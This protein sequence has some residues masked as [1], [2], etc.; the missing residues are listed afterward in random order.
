[1][2]A[3]ND[4]LAV[5][6]RGELPTALRAH[7]RRQLPEV[8]VP[9]RF[10]VLDRLPQLPNGKVD[11]ARLVELDTAEPTGDAYV[12]PGTPEEA[13][14]ALIWQDVLGLP[15]VGVRDDF[16][17][18][19]GDSVA[20]TQVVARVRDELGLAVSVR[21]MFDR[22]TVA[23]LVAAGSTRPVAGNARSIP[24]AELAAEAVLPDDV[25]PVGAPPAPPYRR[26]LLTGGTGYTGAFL[27]REVL[28]R[29]D[30]H[31]V[32]LA[33]ARDR[34]H[35]L[36]RV[37][38]TLRTYGLWQ[39]E[40]AGRVSALP[41]ELA[42]PYLGLD[43][44]AYREVAQ[45]CEVILH[46]GATSSYALPYRSL[47]AA[48]VLGTLEVLRLAGRGRV[49]PVHFVSSLAVFPGDRGAH[50]YPEAPLGGAEGVVGGYRQTKWVADRMVT[51]AAAR[52]LPVSVYRP[53][54]ITGAQDTGACAEDTFLNAM[55]KGCVQL[56]AALEFD[57]RLEMTPVDVC[58]AT[59]AHTALVR[60]EHGQIV[61]LPGARSV[62]W[63]ELVELMAE[64][65]Y[66]LRRLPYPQ[67][68]AELA[69]AAEL[70]RFLPLFGP[71]GPSADLG[72]EH[73][74][75]TFETG[76]LRRL[77]AGTDIAYRPVD[78][79]LV[80]TYLDWFARTGFLPALAGERA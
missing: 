54:Q 29:S 74:V 76:T 3:A 49:K 61:H 56:G 9:A 20:A 60:G 80:G 69:A 67:W 8:M 44:A 45:S 51:A 79:G 55:I 34:A 68:Y 39:P 78:A 73:A 66:G 77:L 27:L 70:A 43:R 14:V 17:A 53:G 57:V 38:A 71:D 26:V 18:L 40:F 52:G 42:R 36:Q 58:A 13:A 16:F 6:A 64:C 7:A 12:P 2:T 35:A 72:Y 47:K 19:G 59:I 30:A 4:P 11:R 50:R 46:N 23:G 37:L 32:V 28:R 22:P 10:V 65:G 48:N 31:V 63:T 75:P 15:R 24:A 41:G 33:R 21:R 62:S 5:A 25:R 1:V